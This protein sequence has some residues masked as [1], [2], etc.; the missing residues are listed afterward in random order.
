ML[1]DT[2]TGSCATA[3]ATPLAATNVTK[4]VFILLS[5]LPT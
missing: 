4:R 1:P 2:Y 3:P 5:S